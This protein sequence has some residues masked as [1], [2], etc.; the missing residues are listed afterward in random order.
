MYN[1]NMTMM[2]TTSLADEMVSIC[3]EA[4]QY[5]DGVQV[6]AHL[7]TLEVIYIDFIKVPTMLRRQGIASQILNEFTQIADLYGVK[8]K[9][10]ASTDFNTPLPALFQLYTQAGFTPSPDGVFTYYP[11]T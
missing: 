6:I 4:P 7:D 1:E 5:G 10:Y 2:I 8:I 9:L 3:K 11:G